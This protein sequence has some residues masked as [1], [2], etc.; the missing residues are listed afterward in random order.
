MD[1]VTHGLVGLSIGELAPKKTKYRRS[2]GLFFG[3]LPD[4]TNLVFVHPYLGWM[5]GHKI[6]FATP[7]DFIEFPQILDHWTYQSWLL[8][9]SLLF[10]AILF[11]PLWNKGFGARLASLAYA[12]HIVLDIPSHS[13]IYG[14]E[15]FYPIPYIFDGWFDAWLWGPGPI[16]GSISLASITY[17]AIRRIRN[18]F[19]WPSERSEISNSP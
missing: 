9:H 11:L 5:A 14:L 3:I 7:Q 1:I 17:L 10:W 15:P 18:S 12:S 13:G 2:I 4:I 16:L 8:T 6:P 19:L